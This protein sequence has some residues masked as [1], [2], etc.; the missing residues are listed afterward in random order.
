[1]IKFFKNPETKTFENDEFFIRIL[2][3][4][5]MYNIHTES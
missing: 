3:E 5:I 1:M 2:I 4:R